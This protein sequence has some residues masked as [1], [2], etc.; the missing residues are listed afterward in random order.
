MYSYTRTEPFSR[1]KTVVKVKAVPETRVH[2]VISYIL[3]LCGTHYIAFYCFLIFVFHIY[4]LFFTTITSSRID[5]HK[6]MH[7]VIFRFFLETAIIKFKLRP[8]FCLPK[9]LR[10]SEN[11]N[12]IFVMDVAD[13]KCNAKRSFCRCVKSKDSI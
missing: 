11:K 8:R 7:P 10:R 13:R 6:P 3:C 4:I 1:A 2:T 12:N 5:L 9:R